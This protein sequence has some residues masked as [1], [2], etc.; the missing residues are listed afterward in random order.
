VSS[1]SATNHDR[2]M[3][4]MKNNH[5][6]KILRWGGPMGRSLNVT[7]D[8]RYI[9]DMVGTFGLATGHKL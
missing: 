5:V 1:I 8:R 3:L 9:L 7:G 2:N 6:G 4:T